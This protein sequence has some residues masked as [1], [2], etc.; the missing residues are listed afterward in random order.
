MGRDSNFVISMYGRATTRRQVLG[1]AQTPHSPSEMAGPGV[2]Y[3]S[4]MGRDRL[5]EE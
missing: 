5:R 2:G 1:M 3:M 4:G